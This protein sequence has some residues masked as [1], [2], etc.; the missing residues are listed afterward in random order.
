MTARHGGPKI[1]LS[2]EYRKSKR[3]FPRATPGWGRP[4]E[5]RQKALAFPIC[6]FASASENRLLSLPLVDRLSDCVAP[7]Q[8]ALKTEAG[9]H[10]VY[11]NGLDPQSGWWSHV[12]PTR[13]R[14]H[15]R[16]KASPDACEQDA[17]Y[18]S[19]YYLTPTCGA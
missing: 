8:R 7:Y 17:H 2:P 6:G 10:N 18:C 15:G 4:R 5:W 3:P 1:P 11:L 12:V 9:Q 19:R 13:T 16:D 14:A